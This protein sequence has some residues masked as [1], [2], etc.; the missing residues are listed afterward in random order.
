MQKLC[1]RAAARLGTVDI[2]K[3]LLVEKCEQ[4]CVMLWL[5]TVG[6]V[7][8]SPFCHYYLLPSVS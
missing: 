2:P 3:I 8:V 6:G 1:L 5:C 4:C 7:R